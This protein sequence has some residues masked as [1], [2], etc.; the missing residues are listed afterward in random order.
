MTI[1]NVLDRVERVRR[2]NGGWMALC[3]AHADTKPSLSIREGENGVVLLKCH[4]GCSYD[5][6]KTALGMPERFGH[7]NEN[8]K[9][10]IAAT[11][12]YTD[13]DGDIL[14]QV[15]R[16]SP[17]AFSQRRPDGRGGWIWNL[18]GVEPVIFN[19]PAVSDAI[20]RGDPVFCVEGERDVLTLQSLGLAGTCNSGGAGK[21][22]DS[23]SSALRGADVVILPDNDDTGRKHGDA[24]AMS[25]LGI[26]SRVRMLSLPDLPEKGDFTNWI[27]AGRTVASLLELV[28]SVSE[29]KPQTQ[30]GL[31]LVRLR[32]LLEEP[33]AAF[34][35][36]VDGILILG[37]LSILAAKPKV[38]KST[39]ARNLAYAVATGTPFLRREVSQGAVIYLALEEKRDEVKKHFRD[40]GASGDEP[41]LIYADTA[42]LDALAKVRVEVE[43]HAPKVIIIDTLFKFQRVKDQN[44]Y[45]EV[46]AALEPL[47]SLA[48]KSGAHVLLTHHMGKG[49]RNDA[50]GIL[51]SQAIFANA[52]T[53]MM[54]VRSE[55]YRTVRTTQRYGDD[56]PETVLTFDTAARRIE[57]GES[58]ERI[59]TH[60]LSDEIVECLR[61][62][63]DLTEN[64]IGEAVDGRTTIKRRALRD[65]VQARVV[66]R[67]GTGKRGEPYRYRLP[68]TCS[69]VPNIYTE[70]ENE[71]VI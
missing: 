40:M 41:I 32:D 11:Y 44:S 55:K 35:W 8:R 66:E 33:D 30:G 48:R 70:Q 39:L 16:Y 57:L 6:I 27:A 14:Y 68:D 49:D 54:L 23:L 20:E 36:L 56:L 9:Q 31:N 2:T 52:D 10:N 53:A 17:K 12:D 50:E 26:A 43:A 25:L 24:V 45:A 59:D 67:I 34:T 1:E 18:E 22:R 15:V 5:E 71:K 58:R 19:W 65:L 28:Q 46:T 64:E 3:P 13:R 61:N 38:G 21:W 60:W 37:G 7:M 42:P 69:L 51:G 62:Q 47:L 4:A 29:W 63:P